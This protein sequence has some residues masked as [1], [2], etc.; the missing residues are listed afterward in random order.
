[1]NIVFLNTLNDE[2]VI[3]DAG[4]PRII[5]M[6]DEQLKIAARIDLDEIK[7]EFWDLINDFQIPIRLKFI[8]EVKFKELL[9]M[10]TSEK[11]GSEI[12]VNYLEEMIVPFIQRHLD[13]RIE[14][15]FNDINV[16]TTKFLI[17]V[18]KLL[19]C[20]K[21]IQSILEQCDAFAGKDEEPPKATVSPYRLA[22]KRK[23]DFMK[24]LSAM[25]DTR[26]FVNRDGEPAT[27]KQKLMEAFGEFLGEDFSTYSTSLSQAK[28][29][30]SKTFMKPFTE[31]E[32]QAQR[33]YNEVEE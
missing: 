20:R 21:E 7:Y 16:I 17:I 27:N 11:Y 33:Y 31:I 1:M 8:Y 4:T 9:S 13:K 19:T 15:S 10:K 6:L 14:I 24:I 26:M 29:R 28:N 32:E 18:S 30:D 23:T 2:F 5:E 12:I 3:Y 25:Y 22:S